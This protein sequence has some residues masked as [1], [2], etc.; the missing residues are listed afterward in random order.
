MRLIFISGFSRSGTTYLQSLVATQKNI[1]S[2]P[3]THFF[4]YAS[5]FVKDGNNVSFSELKEINLRLKKLA[6]F[7]F[8]EEERLLLQNLANIGNLT[9]KDIFL[10]LLYSQ[11]QQ[12]NVA[13]EADSVWVEKTPDHAR[14]LFEIYNF[15]PEAYFI[16]IL[17]HP[18]DAIQSHK[19]KI[20]D[21]FGKTSYS[22]LAKSWMRNVTVILQFQEKY[23]NRIAVL[24]LEELEKNP[25]QILSEAFDR[26]GLSLER[27]LLKNYHR[28]AKEVTLPFEYWKANN[29]EK[30]YKKESYLHRIPK[31]ELLKIQS[32]MKEEMNQFGYKYYFCLAQK[33]YNSLKFSN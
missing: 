24:K 6:L 25:V 14:N 31:R 33:V 11:A 29:M 10:K 17:R 21:T 15:F 19:E 2:L 23:P 28:K 18:I 8:T 16:C 1:V 20:G 7:E 5:N 22:S 30:N 13:F 12:R 32:L 26:F 3:E 27:E 4:D 9:K